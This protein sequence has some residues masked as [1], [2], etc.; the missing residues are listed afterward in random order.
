M[1]WVFITGMGRSGTTFLGHVLGAAHGG[2]AEHERIAN[3]AFTTHSWYLD[4]ALYA[5]PYLQ[6]VRNDLE[7]SVG[8][9]LNTSF[10]LHGDPVVMTPADSIY[11]F[12]KS[13]LEVLQL[14][15][16]V[17]EKKLESWFPLDFLFFILGLDRFYFLFTLG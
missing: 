8:G 6:R 9:V 5:V 13:G 1:K 10:N 16:Y 15:N 7:R 14:E 2:D 12:L 11:T 17:I 3:R 4:D